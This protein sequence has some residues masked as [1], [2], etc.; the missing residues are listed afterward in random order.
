MKADNPFDKKLEASKGVPESFRAALTEVTDTLDFAWASA[1]SVFEK[2][3]TPE[4]AIMLL[5]II[6]A[7]ADAER[8]RAQGAPEA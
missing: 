3:A 6:L 7:R 1:Q 8:R 5:P 2:R 4:H